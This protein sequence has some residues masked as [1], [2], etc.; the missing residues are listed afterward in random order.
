MQIKCTEV[1]ELYKLLETIC[2][3]EHV[4]IDISSFIVHALKW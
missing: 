4:S 3:W 2:N 1:L